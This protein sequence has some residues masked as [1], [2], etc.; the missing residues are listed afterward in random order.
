MRVTKVQAHTQAH[1]YKGGNPK[2]I[3]FNVFVVNFRFIVKLTS[4]IYFFI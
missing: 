2:T 4:F 3:Y 1:T